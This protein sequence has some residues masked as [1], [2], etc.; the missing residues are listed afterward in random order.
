MKFVPV[1]VRVNPAPPAPTLVG[2][3]EPSVGAGLLIVNV[4]AL[5][6]PP[7]GVGLKIVTGAVPGVAMSLAEIAARSSVLLKK[8]VDRSL[9]FQR[10]TDEAMKF[11]PVA[12]RGNPA[13]PAA[14]LVG[15]IELSVGA[16]LLLIV[17]VCALEAPPPGVGLK[18]VTGAV[19]AVATSFARICAWSW[20]LLTK[21]V[22]RLAPFQRTT[23][24]LLKFVPV[25]VSV[26]A[27]LP[28]TA[29][30]G[31]IELSVGAGLLIVN[32]EAPEVPPPGVGLKT[33]T[34][35][36]P[37]AAMSFASIWARSWVLLTKVVVRLVP[38]QRTTDVTAKF[39]PVVVS[40]KAA[41]PATTLVG[42]IEVS[43]GA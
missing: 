34:V 15:E 4:C 9:P 40:V 36:V 42:L 37:V 38:F 6:R 41:P 29:L 32:V 22:V 20:V 18:T 33:V 1:A 17:N 21:V 2:E 7:P 43:V 19:P 11:V 23:D 8:V 26:N 31:E 27:P 12:I 3:I 39:V 10:T 30:V 5:E 14:T 13:P 16:G 28:A 35:A 24:E 25:A